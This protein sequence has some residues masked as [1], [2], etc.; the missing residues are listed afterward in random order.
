[1]RCDP[2]D[3]LQPCHLASDRKTR[4][5]LAHLRMIEASAP[6]VSQHQEET[7]RRLEFFNGIGRSRKTGAG[8]DRAVVG[9]QQRMVAAGETGD[10]I[11]EA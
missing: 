8:N 9:Q 3:G 7:C 5:Q 10:C 11:G 2:F 6:V 1:M 4:L